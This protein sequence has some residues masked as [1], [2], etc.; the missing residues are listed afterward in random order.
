V[1]G[2]GTVKQPMLGTGRTQPGDGG[3]LGHSWGAT[4]AQMLLTGPSDAL[5]EQL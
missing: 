5:M 2:G 4:E 3:C 1:Q